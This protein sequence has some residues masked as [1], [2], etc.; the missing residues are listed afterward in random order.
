MSDFTLH[1]ALWIAV[2]GTR[3]GG[4]DRI[5]LLAALGEHGSI[6]RAAKAV[7][8]SYKA[9]WDAVEA[10]NNLAGE[11]LVARTTGGRGGGGTR[12]TARGEKLVR[13]FRA[14]EH[15]HR[16]LLDELARP[17]TG[18]AD[19]ALLIRRMTLKTSARNQFQGR[20]L[21]LARG[22][23][24]DEVTIA[25][26]GG[27]PLVAVLTRSSTAS[28]GLAVGREVFALVKAS[29]VVLVTGAAEARFS[30]R[31]QLTGTIRRI[32]RG[33]VHSEVVL[34]LP[35]AGSLA[36]VITNRSR[37]ALGLTVG[38]PVTALFKASSVILGTTD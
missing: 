6:T 24:N 32:E 25:I 38:M 30:A 23:V 21:A 34:D 36:A 33:A 26:A 15:E 20:I 9:A 13:N 22:A 5:A 31:N 1:A 7:G 28:L 2:G 8:I 3:F 14:L 18:I 12:L 27:N 19:D 35:T 16:R 4:S 11:A 37:E 17:S 10:M 29:S